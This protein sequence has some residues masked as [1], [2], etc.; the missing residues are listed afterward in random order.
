MSC[1]EKFDLLGDGE[2]ELDEQAGHVLAK[3]YAIEWTGLEVW[4]RYSWEGKV[5]FWHE[6]TGGALWKDKPPKEW[7]NANTPDGTVW[8]FHADNIRFFREP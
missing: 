1:G 8:W 2:D 3:L 5:W 4:E 7:K 6:E